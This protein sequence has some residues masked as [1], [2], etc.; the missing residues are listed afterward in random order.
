MF[1]YRLS[2]INH[3]QVRDG[4]VFLSAVIDDKAFK[5]IKGYLD[6]AKEGNDGAK[7]GGEIDF[8]LAYW[9]WTRMRDDRKCCDYWLWSM[10]YLFYHFILRWSRKNFLLDLAKFRFFSDYYDYKWVIVI[11]LRLILQILL[12]GGCDDSKGYYIEP[13]LIEVTDPKSKLITEVRR[14]SCVYDFFFLPR[15]RKGSGL[16]SRCFWY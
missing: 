15:H 10:I 5:R 9:L 4:S 3:S 2:F 8:S 13:T 11:N 7:V 1:H 16:F 14:L 12:G 6:Y